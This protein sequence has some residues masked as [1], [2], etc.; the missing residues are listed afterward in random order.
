MLGVSSLDWHGTSE[1]DKPSCIVV[2]ADQ[3]HARP[4]SCLGPGQGKKPCD[5]RDRRS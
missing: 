1:G 5:R 2:G 4:C 3:R